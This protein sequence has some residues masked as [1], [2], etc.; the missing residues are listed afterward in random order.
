VIPESGR[1]YGAELTLRDAT[2]GALDWWVSYVWSK[3]E[4][5]VDGD[6]VPR[7]W[8]QRHAL[9]ANIEW[10]GDKWTFSAV[11]RYHSGWP[12]TP[13]NVNLVFDSAGNVIGVETDLS[14]RN[15]AEF[16]DYS[17]LDIRASRR[18]ELNRGSFEYYFEL[19]NVFDAG[20]Q[21][22]T[23]NHTLILGQGAS[24]APEFD[25]FLPRFP[26]FGFIWRFGPGAE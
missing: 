10:R 13:L 24:V 20:N 26:S 2:T 12:R 9:T 7:T 18:V 8:D 17:R 25:E 3:A 22:C 5:M 19:F 11:G 16:D 23:S 21:C 4:D 1:A 15:S 6:W 14:A